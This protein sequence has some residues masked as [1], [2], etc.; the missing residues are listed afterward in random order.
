MRY[1]S[2]S[3]LNVHRT[4][5][6]KAYWRYLAG[7]YGEDAT[8][9]LEEPRANTNL[10]LGIAWHLGAELL[11]MGASGVEAFAK[12]NAELPPEDWAQLSEVERQWLLAA[13]LG[14]ERAKQDEFLDRYE[15][16]SVEEELET[17]I[18]PN[19]TL[20]SRADAAVLDR[21]DGS[22]WVVNWKTA[23]EV[24]DW[25]KKWFFEPQA[26]LESLALESRLGVPVAGCLF[27]GIWKGPFYRGETTSRLL[28][29]YRY[30]SRT[31]LTYGTENNG[32]GVRFSAWKEKFP[33]GEG[34][35]A[36]VSWLPK[37]ILAKHFVESAPQIR[38]DALVEAWLKQLTRNEHDIDHILSTGSAE[39]VE[40]FFWQNWGEETCGRCPFQN[41]CMLRSTPEELL[42][43]GFL[44]PRH[45]SPRDE[46]AGRK[47][48]EG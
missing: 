18:T 1:I 35:A 44:K 19:V 33:F 24:K 34:L 25:N 13:F 7:P 5:P 17:P 27:L 4:C 38:Q 14:W 26:W 23:S 46:V 41:L 21:A 36:W 3:S 40:T 2:N 39:D 37:D 10:I 11:L 8:L 31:G 12:A 43:D 45:R 22:Y 28:F 32:G 6:R 20:Y 16:L 29:G 15:V 42:K 47:K 30:N 48:N 9:G